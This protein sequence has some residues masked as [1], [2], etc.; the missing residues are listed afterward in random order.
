MSTHLSNLRGHIH[1]T[2]R[3]QQR[4]GRNDRAG[5]RELSL[6]D[7]DIA[8]CDLWHRREQLMTESFASLISILKC[9][10]GV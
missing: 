9:E 8:V 7:I 2:R 5:Q 4:V 6:P 10:N 3:L 1:D